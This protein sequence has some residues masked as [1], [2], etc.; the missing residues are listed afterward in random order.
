MVTICGKKFKYCQLYYG[1]PH[2]LL[3]EPQ[4]FT[5]YATVY[6]KPLSR[7]LRNHGLECH[8]FADEPQLFVFMEPVQAQVD[9]CVGRLE[10][11]CSDIRAWM[12]RNFL[13]LND[14]KTES[15]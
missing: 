5:V 12:G 8:F 1:V 13:K 2:V 6:T 10:L 15:C 7:I 4:L 9:G 11:C 3:L 14:D